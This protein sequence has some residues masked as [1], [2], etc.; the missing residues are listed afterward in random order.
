MSSSAKCVRIAILLIVGLASSDTLLWAADG[1]Q[2]SAI[3]ASFKFDPGDHLVLVPVRVGGN[4]YPFVVDTGCTYSMFDTSLKRQ[5]GEKTGIVE[6]NT[7]NPPIRAETYSPSHVTVGS[8]PLHCESAAC[9]NFALMR[10]ALGCDCFGCLGLDFLNE[11]I[12]VIDFDQGRL[13]ILSPTTMPK[14]DWGERVDLEV[15]SG[16]LWHLPVRVSDNSQMM[17]LEVD[18][19]N[20]CTGSLGSQ[21]FSQLAVFGD[22][23]VTS[24]TETVGVDGVSDGRTGRLRRFR[25][26]PFESENLR[27]VQS[28]GED[29]DGNLGL[30]YLRRFRVVLDFSRGRMFLKKGRHFADRDHG[31]MC[32]MCLLFKKNGILVHSV[33]GNGPAKAAGILPKDLIVAIDE[34]P[35]HEIKTSAI[36]RLLATEGKK[37]TMTIDRNGKKVGAA[38]TLKELD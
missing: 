2:E 36:N 6:W 8:L 35:V 1:S 30:G 3:R 32:G 14:R 31:P 13:D 20:S 29:A 10:E 25:V 37:I 23:R 38:F 22:I 19:G 17:L 15:G 28:H 24:Q 12:V 18:T 11:W 5:L 26:G 16:A 21:L 9:H 7:P 33:D 27:F 34:K 4:E